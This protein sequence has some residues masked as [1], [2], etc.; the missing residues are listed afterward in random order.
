MRNIM[1][2]RNDVGSLPTGEHMWIDLDRQGNLVGITIEHARTNAGLQEL[3]HQ[4]ILSQPRANC[5]T[6]A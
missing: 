4:E 1:R 5:P 2:K 6:M 3:S